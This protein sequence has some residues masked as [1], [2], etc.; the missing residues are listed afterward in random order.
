MDGFCQSRKV[1]GSQPPRKALHR[2]REGIRSRDRLHYHETHSAK[3]RLL[4]LREPSSFRSRRDSFRS[5]PQLPRTRRPDRG[6]LGT[7]APEYERGRHIGYQ[8]P[9]VVGNTAGSLDSPPVPI[10]H[11]LRLCPRRDVQP[12]AEKTPVTNIA[13]A[14]R[15]NRNRKER[16]QA[17]PKL[18]SAA[19][20]PSN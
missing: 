9:V 15:N 11:T 17:G 5:R 8:P 10:L 2:G 14:T 16:L 18:V 12:Q 4:D 13:D 1:P 3:H 6:N 7:D 20:D 19:D